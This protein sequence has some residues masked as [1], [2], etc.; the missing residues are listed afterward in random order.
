MNSMAGALA[1]HTKIHRS[2]LGPCNMTQ[3]GASGCELVSKH[4][5][6]T[7]WIEREVGAGFVRVAAFLPVSG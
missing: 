1:S 5:T 4:H 2:D 3:R 7:R 6:K